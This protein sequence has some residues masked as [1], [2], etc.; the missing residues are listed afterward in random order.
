MSETDALVPGWTRFKQGKTQK[1]RSPDGTVYGYWAYS[2]VYRHYRNTGETLDVPPGPRYGGQQRNTSS[3]PHSEDISWLDNEP[4]TGFKIE[5]P[6][7]KPTPSGKTAKGLFTAKQL[8]EGFGTGLIIL[9]SIAAAATRVP[10]IQMR[11][12]EVK[13]ISIPLGNITERSKYNATIGKLLVDNSDYAIMGYALYQYIDRVSTAINER[14]QA[15]GPIRNDSQVAS[16]GQSGISNGNGYGPAP[17]PYSPK[18]LRGI[19]NPNG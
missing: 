5:M 15:N 16:G 2:K 14:K 17:L 8:S 6:E 19:V 18:G 10:E 4:E 12:N 7:P 11:E 1:Y 9:T 3:Q 13:A